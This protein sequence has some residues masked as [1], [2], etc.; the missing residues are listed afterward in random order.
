MTF[1]APGRAGRVSVYTALRGLN[2][3]DEHPTGANHQPRKRLNDKDTKRDSIAWIKQK[4]AE[5][6]AT[7]ELIVYLYKVTIYTLI[8]TV[9][10]SMFSKN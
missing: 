8:W 3:C 10:V 9:P 4:V 7:A 6:A 2:R 1:T 5:V